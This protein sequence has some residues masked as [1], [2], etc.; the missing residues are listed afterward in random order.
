[1]GEPRYT[2]EKSVL[3]TK[4]KVETS[5]RLLNFNAVV[6]DGLRMLHGAV[7]WPNGGT[8]ADLINGVKNF[9]LKYLHFADVYLTFDRYYN[10]SMKSYTR[11]AMVKSFTRGHNLFRQSPLPSK[12]D[13][14]SCTKSKV[15]LIQQI[16]AGLVD[17]GLTEKNRLAITSNDHCPT[18]L[19]DEKKTF[20][21]DSGTGHE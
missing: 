21:S 6:I 9:V 1:M 10:Y 20:R 15:Q 8:L 7:H 17:I 11:I 13:T 12:D 16:S 4:L 3:Q 14:L 18:E 2:K 19:K 5:L